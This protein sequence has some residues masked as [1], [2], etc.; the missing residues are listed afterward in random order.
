MKKRH[1]LS[2]LLMLA[3]LLALPLAA[4]AEEFN[5]MNLGTCVAGQELNLYITNVPNEAGVY[6]TSV[7]A[8]TDLNV[9]PDG[10]SGRLYLIGAP[11]YA[12]HYEL[13]IDVDARQI[14][15]SLDV[16]P[17]RP[18]LLTPA[19][20]SCAPGDP[21]LLTASATVADAGELSFQ[22]YE[23]RGA[24]SPI[25][26]AVGPSYEPDTSAPGV[27][28]YVVEVTNNNNGFVS[29]VRSGVIEIRVVE[30]TVIGVRIESLPRKTEYVEGDELDVTGL[31]VLVSY[32]NGRSAVVTDGFSVSPTSFPS[33]GTRNVTVSYGGFNCGFNV[34][35]KARDK[36]VEGI[37]VVTLPRKT[38][39]VLGESLQTAGLSIRCY[40]ADGGHFDVSAGL[41]CFPTELREEGSQ[42]I[43]V[44]YAEKTCSFTVHVKNDKIVTGV[45][46]L[47]MPSRLTYTVGDMIE[48]AGLSLQL[49][50][51]KGSETVTAGYTVTPKVLASPGTQEITVL[52]GQYSTKFSVSV[53]PKDSVVPS[54]RVSNT[55]APAPTPSASPLPAAVD[56]TGAPSASPAPPM[57]TSPVRENTGV[58]LGVKLVFA[59]AVLSL[60]GLAVYIWYLR[61]NG[62]DGGEA[63]ADADAQTKVYGEP[64]D[65]M[66][67][68]RGSDRRP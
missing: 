30:P 68:P 18:E 54:P 38:E 31:S 19:S 35:V 3:L 7:P 58:G 21:L 32:D 55:P 6:P 13:V 48:T 33:A 25:P 40:T 10:E 63:A 43:T 15:C 45:S 52:Y 64:V 66:K 36:T 2:L 29:T 56:T 14:L 11:M 26:D 22:W 17:A 61:R 57:P 62:F 42:T 16:E 23:E 51:N 24:L 46:I 20:T 50:S 37:G 4:H 59:V 67:P 49:N 60:A 44:R 27:H 65:P 12:G 1:L 8:G 53:K 47:T 34:T 39:Y 41:D 9:V 5:S 28:R